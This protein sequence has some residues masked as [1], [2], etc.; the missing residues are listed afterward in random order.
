[1][2]AL[3][4]A[5]TKKEA[6]HHGYGGSHNA[7][8]TEDNVKAF[9]EFKSHEKRGPALPSSLPTK[10]MREEGASGEKYLQDPILLSLVWLSP[11]SNFSR[12]R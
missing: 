9:Q 12:P 10:P 4:S 6:E 7:R 1:M 8:F 3:C 5:A 2:S 11:S